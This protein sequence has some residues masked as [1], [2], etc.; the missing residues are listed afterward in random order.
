MFHRRA[1]TRPHVAWH[2]NRF[3]GQGDDAFGQ[4]LAVN[5][6]TLDRVGRTHVLHQYANIRRAA[7]VGHLF[8]GQNLRQLLRTAGRVFRRDDAQA[9]TVAACQH[10]THHRNGLRFIVLNA[11]QHLLRL[12][13]VRQDL[14]TFNNLRRAVLHQAI[15]CGDVRFAFCGVNDQCINFVTAA[16]QLVTRR[17]TRAA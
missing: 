4:R 7:T 14:N 6:G 17:E 13:D 5:N 3:T 10:R 9:D 16:A 2:A 15:V 11:N 1:E 12:Q 8:T